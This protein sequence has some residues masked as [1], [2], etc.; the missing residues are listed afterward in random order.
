MAA[1]PAEKLKTRIVKSLKQARGE[2]T[3]KIRA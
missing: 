2:Q 3:V 1:G